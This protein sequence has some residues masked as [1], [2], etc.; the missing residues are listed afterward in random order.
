MM[1]QINTDPHQSG[2]VYQPTYAVTA[3]FPP[4]QDPRG[5]LPELS[6][7]GFPQSRIQVFTGEKGAA[8]LDLSGEQHGAWVRFQRG[9]EK[10]LADEN[11]IYQRVDH[12]LRSGGWVVEAFTSGDAAKKEQA[13]RIFKAHH[14]QEILYWGEWTIETL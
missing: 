9:L 5:A 6:E 3:F 10:L 11:E 8:L 1:S 12:L 2:Y 7:A 4:G 13:V 14:A